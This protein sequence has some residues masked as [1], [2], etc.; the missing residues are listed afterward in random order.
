[1]ENGI[2]SKKVSQGKGRGI[3]GRRK[4][5]NLLSSVPTSMRQSP[6]D[7]GCNSAR[8]QPGN[9]TAKNKDSCNQG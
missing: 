3:V 5:G 6:V 7:L 8:L 2:G 1:M 4:L 9:L